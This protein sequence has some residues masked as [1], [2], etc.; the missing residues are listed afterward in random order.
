[1]IDGNS[2]I[3]SSPE[4]AFPIAVRYAWAD[5]P[6]CNLYNGVNLPASPFRTDD[7]QG[8]LMVI[9]RYSC[10]DLPSEIDVT[11]KKITMNKLL[12]RLIFQNIYNQ[13][14]ITYEKLLCNFSFFLTLSMG[15]VDICFHVTWSFVTEQ[16]K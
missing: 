1:M 6:I 14:I 10:F 16:A 8:I 12:F 4:V 9:N 7:W 11:H 3:V 13:F 2:I 5:N 15:G